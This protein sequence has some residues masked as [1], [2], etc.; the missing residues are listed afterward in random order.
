MMISNGGDIILERSDNVI[1]IQG[2]CVIFRRV[3]YLISDPQKRGV[4]MTFV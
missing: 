4:Y 1:V 2:V 3:F